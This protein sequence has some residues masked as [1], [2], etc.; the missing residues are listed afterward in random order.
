MGR[1]A[2]FYIAPL[3]YN[4]CVLKELDNLEKCYQKL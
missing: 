1:Q 4:L 2:V 3:Y